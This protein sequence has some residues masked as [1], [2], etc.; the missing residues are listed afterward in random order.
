[1]TLVHPD[2]FRRMP[3]KQF[4][5]AL[6]AVFALTILSAVVFEPLHAD[7]DCTGDDS[8]AVCLVIQLVQAGLRNADVGSSSAVFLACI[9]A[10]TIFLGARAIFFVRQTPVSIK[11]RLND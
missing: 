3:Q 8:C 10:L 7:H 1:M 6:A 2:F 5:R 4:V 9:F 11:I